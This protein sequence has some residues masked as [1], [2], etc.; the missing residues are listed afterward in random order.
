[1][2]AVVLLAVAAAGGQ[3]APTDL[4]VILAGDVTDSAAIIW[5]SLG[6]RGVVR[7][8]YGPTPALGRVSPPVLSD[9]ASGVAVVELGGLQPGTRY[10]Y[11]VVADLRGRRVTSLVGQFPT[12]PPPDAAAG[13]TL[14]WGADTSERFHPW[15]IF[16]AIRAVQPDAFLYLGDTVYADVDC[17]A[18]TLDQYRACYRR[19]RDDEAFARFARAVPVWAMWDD[20][21]VANNFDR[22][23][24]RLRIGL[25][26]FREAWPIRPDPADPDRLYRSFRWGRLVEVILLD[27]RQY[28]DPS[29][30]PDGPGKTMLGEAQRAWLLEALGRSSAVFLVVASSVTLRFAGADSWEGYTAERQQIL[31]ALA[32]HGGAVV[33]SGDVHYAAVV[34]HPEGVTEATVGPLAMLVASR[35]RAAGSVHTVFAY[36]GGFTFGVVRVEPSPPRLVL[37]VHD[38]QGRVLYRTAVPP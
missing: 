33:L 32:R 24:P 11:R 18:R 30:A 21:E 8:E 7:V 2:W 28:R 14:A 1:V 35:A 27:T 3:S 23:H 38:G 37:Q 26:A 25:R 17:G 5:T 12:A 22:T 31:Q 20:H 16:D 29:S 19:A 9:D 10:F 4:G 36:R 34:R 6:T 13:L 15:R